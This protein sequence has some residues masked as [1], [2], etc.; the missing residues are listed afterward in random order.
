MLVLQRVKFVRVDDFGHF[1]LSTALSP[2]QE[3][4][5][6]LRVPPLMD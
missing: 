2:I 6:G 5:L 1:V 4:L 3:F